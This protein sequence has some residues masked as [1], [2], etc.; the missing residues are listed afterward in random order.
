MNI[1]AAIFEGIADFIRRNPIFSLVVLILA[2]GAPSVLKGVAMF[3][4]YALL[5]IAV[6]VLIAVFAFRA[7]IKRMQR[8]MNDQWQSGS[9]GGGF[10]GG[11]FSGF[12]GFN[13]NAKQQ[14]QN[15][16][17]GEVKVHKTSDASQKRVSGDVGDYVDFEDVEQ[18]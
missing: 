15:S 14:Q 5:G 18:K 4:L 3:I 6:L 1:I 13:P 17:E 7:K 12:G 2:I 11:G 9:T 8:E 10:S 16:H